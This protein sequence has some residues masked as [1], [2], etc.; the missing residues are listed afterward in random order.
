MLTSYVTFDPGSHKL[1]YEI[2]LSSKF[3]IEIEHDVV[4]HI[5][6]TGKLGATTEK[7]NKLFGSTRI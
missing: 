5:C 7:G 2:P 6:T 4:D 3:S 1:K